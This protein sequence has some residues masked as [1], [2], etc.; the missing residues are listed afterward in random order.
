MFQALTG[1]VVLTQRHVRPK[2][3]FISTHGGCGITRLG[4]QETE[5]YGAY[6]QQFIGGGRNA[7]TRAMP[8]AR[9]ELVEIKGHRFHDHKFRRGVDDCVD[10]RRTNR[11]SLYPK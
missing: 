2:R 1:L 7:T 3:G 4:Q 11:I 10:Y 9:V 6:G 5:I 8:M